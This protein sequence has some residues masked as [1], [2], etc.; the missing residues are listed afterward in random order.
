MALLSYVHGDYC[1]AV[2]GSRWCD[3]ADQSSHIISNCVERNKQGGTGFIKSKPQITGPL[4][5]GTSS[6]ELMHV[7]LDLGD[8]RGLSLFLWQDGAPFDDVM[9]EYMSAS[10]P[11][12]IDPSSAV[13]SAQNASYAMNMDEVNIAFAHIL[14]E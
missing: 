6:D 11:S 4:Y 7:V 3:I 9:N 5:V 8:M 13:L 14:R 12:G 10:F 1:L 2:S